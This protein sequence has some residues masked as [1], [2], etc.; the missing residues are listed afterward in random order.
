MALD[1]NNLTRI[2]ENIQRIKDAGLPFSEAERYI[3]EKEG[4]DPQEV[5]GQLS[6]VKSTIPPLMQPQKSPWYHF[7]M[8]PDKAELPETGNVPIIKPLI[9]DIGSAIGNPGSRA[10]QHI[11]PARSKG[12]GTSSAKLQA[13]PPETL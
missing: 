3:K 11:P 10:K 12:T 2:K 1:A 7:G 9:S 5:F 13:L 6:S 4:F 8:T